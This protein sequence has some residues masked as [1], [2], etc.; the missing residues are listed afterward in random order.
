[1][2]L[3]MKENK[4]GVPVGN[5]VCKF[6]G[7][8]TNTHPEHGEGL[9]WQF[10]VVRGPHAG[11]KTSRTTGTVPSAKNACGRML[12]GLTGGAISPGAEVNLAHFVGKKYLV[13]V[14]NNST[15]TGTR[16]G[17]VMPSPDEDPVGAP[18]SAPPPPP[19]RNAP[20]APS[21]DLGTIITVDFGN[22][23]PSK[24]TVGE[25]RQLVESG[26]VLA[27]DLYVLQGNS[28]VEWEST[29]EGLPF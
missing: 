10:E 15:N 3:T 17:T 14:E 13:M 26:K 19:R 16:I 2:I 12:G 7:V 5:Y 28:W 23:Q 22:D 8:E 1:M 24:M 20:P 27:K 6:T 25:V 29:V 18:A 11:G 9:E 21:K 4:F